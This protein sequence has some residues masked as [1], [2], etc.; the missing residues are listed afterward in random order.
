MNVERF[1]NWRV[2]ANVERT[3]QIY[4]EIEHSSA[5]E[6]D[7]AYCRHWLGIRDDV[8]PSDF[9]KFLSRLGVDYRKEYDV[10]E[11]E[12]GQV[13][14]GRCLYI[15]NYYFVGEL[16]EGEDGISVYDEGTGYSFRTLPV[17]DELRVGIS[18]RTP[19]QFVPLEFERMRS[20]QV[21]FEIQSTCPPNS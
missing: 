5:E 14:Q 3:K 13:I 7:C 17:T 8:L 12:T 18:S 2:R 10:S 9:R 16:T 21:I 19:K 20:S 1:E 4:A 15:G 11:Y 6:C